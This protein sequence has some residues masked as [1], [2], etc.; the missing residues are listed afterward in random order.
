[1][2]VISKGAERG[3]YSTAK[4]GVNHWTKM[5]ASEMQPYGINV[6]AIKPGAP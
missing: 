6:N 4:A 1:V 2:Q 5:L 3:I